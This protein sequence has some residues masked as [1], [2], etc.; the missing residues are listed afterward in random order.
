MDF[1]ISSNSE[2][3]VATAEAVDRSLR[4]TKGDAFIKRLHNSLPKVSTASSASTQP[5]DP[6]ATTSAYDDVPVGTT[7]AETRAHYVKWAQQIRFEYCDLSLPP[8]ETPKNIPKPNDD[9]PPH[10]RHAYNSDIRMLA[11]SDIPK[12][13]LAIAKEVSFVLLIKRNRAAET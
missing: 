10:Y 1:I 9:G 3:I 5:S 4:E 2:R 6:K 11:N 12:R 8:A 13:S 7:E